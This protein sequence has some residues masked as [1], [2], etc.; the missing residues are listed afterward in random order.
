MDELAYPLKL[1]AHHLLCLLGFRG[2]GYSPAFVEKMGQVLGELQRAPD[3]PITVVTECDIIC[4]S[5]L[6]NLDG[7]CFKS[8]DADS[9][10][11]AKDKAILKTLGFRDNM[12]TTARD[13]WERVKE[14]VTPEDLAKLCSR[15]QWLELSYCREGLVNL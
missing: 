13:A 7:R 3:A 2:L 9:R 1:R 15:C 4:S 5:C 12:Q 11:K 10:I 14:R 8:P 6:H